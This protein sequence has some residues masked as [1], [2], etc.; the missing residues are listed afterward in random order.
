MNRSALTWNEVEDIT[1]GRFGETSAVCPFCSAG[2]RTALKRKHKVLSVKLVE[3]DFAIFHCNHCEASG[4]CRPDRASRSVVDLAEQRRR[5]EEA[6]RR[7]EQDRQA[8]T[9]KALELW[10]EAQPFRGSPAELYLRHSRGI[11]DWLDG[12][13]LLD[14]ALRFHPDCPFGDKRL[15]CMVALVRD[16]QTNVPVAVHRT[17]LTAD[18]YP[19]RIDRMS[20]GPTG[21]GAIKLSA[22]NEVQFDLLIGEGIETVLSASKQLKVR[23]AWSLIDRNGVARFPALQGIEGVTVA[24]D[25]DASGDGQRAAAECVNRLTSSGVDV[26]AVKPTFVGDFNDVIRDGTRGTKFVARFTPRQISREAADFFI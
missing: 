10:N 3:P 22:D 18:R 9:L 17:A 13:R 1:R 19:K 16:V 20:L 2:R 4:Y 21:G 15:P 6:E 8:R 5:R 12:F 23:P 14:E 11:G 7:N 24:V 26:Y 25:N